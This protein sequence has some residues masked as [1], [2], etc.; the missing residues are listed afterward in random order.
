MVT[1]ILVVGDSCV[2]NFVYCDA[3]RLAPDVPIPVLNI[4]NQTTNPGMA[5]NVYR[6]IHNLYDN[7]ELLTNSNYQDIIKMRYMH[8]KSNHAFFRVDTPHNIDRI[9]QRDLDFN[10]DV[11]VV[12]DY[13]KG[14][15]TEDDIAYICDK[16]TWC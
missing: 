3:A 6:N 8:D 14:F 12:S 11:V 4:V 10:A 16:N 7:C 1:K 15:L 13:D 5:A 2:D 9:N